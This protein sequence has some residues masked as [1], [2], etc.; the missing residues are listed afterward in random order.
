[1]PDFS[2]ILKPLF[3]TLWFL[4]P[5][6]LLGGI[7][8]SPWFKGVFGEFQVNLASRLFPDRRVY[9]LIKNVTLPTPGGTTQIDHIIVSKFGVFCVETKN[10]SGWIFGSEHQKEWTQKI[11][12][13]SRRFQN[14]LRQNYKH[15]KT[16]EGL[17]GIPLKSVFSVVVFVGDSTF[18]TE[19]PENVTYAG[20]YVRYIK[21]KALVRLSDAEVSW[22]INKIEERRLEPG[23][24][25]DR[26]H[27]QNLRESREPPRA[28]QVPV[29]PGCASE[30][31]LRKATKGANAGSRFWGCPSYPRC[32]GV[33]NA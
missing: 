15:V 2:P 7:L 8:S 17:L 18:K 11:F 24:R 19:M 28:G 31:V 25:T 6:A 14:P 32:K 23:F 10:M 16:L 9:R 30:M 22:I 27:V 3:S 20:G 5:L 33:R 26:E 1:M 13:Q 29:C 21:S 12:R 4:I